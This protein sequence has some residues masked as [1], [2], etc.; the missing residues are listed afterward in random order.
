MPTAI[1]EILRTGRDSN[2]SYWV[3]ARYSDDWSKAWFNNTIFDMTRNLVELEPT[4]LIFSPENW[5]PLGAVEDTSGNVYRSDYKNHQLLHKLSCE[6]A[7]KPIECPGG[8]GWQTGQFNKPAGVSIDCRGSLLVADSGNHRVQIIKPESQTVIA[9]LG[10][11]SDLGGYL[12]GI[13]NGAMTEPVHAICDPRNYRIYVADRAGG[14]IHVFNDLYEY[15]YSFVPDTLPA[16]GEVPEKPVPLALAIA[17]DGSLL[18]LDANYSRIMRMSIKGK[19][20]SDLGFTTGDANPFIGGRNLQP[21]YVVKGEFVVGP[22][23][24]GVYNQTWH[25]INL[26]SSIPENT[27]V[28]VKSF[29]SNDDSIVDIDTIPWAP[30]EPVPI[31]HKTVTGCKKRPERLVLSDKQN[32][33]RYRHGDYRR[34]RPVISS[35]E[36]GDGP[37]S[38]D[39]VSIS[40]E[41]ARI[42]RVGDTVVFD[43]GASS[44]QLEIA[45]ISETDFRA[46]ANGVAKIYSQDTELWLVEQNGK[47][48]PG[49][50][51]HFYTLV[52]GELVDLSTAVMN[53]RLT[54]VVV[55]HSVA[56]IARIGDRLELRYAGDT[57]SLEIESVN[58]KQITNVVMSAAVGG[59][60][61]HS[62]LSLETSP[63]RLVCD[64]IY[65]FDYQ[66]ARHLK[67]TVDDEH[68]AEVSLV[69]PDV[70]TIWLEPGSTVEFGKWNY[71]TTMLP[72]ATDRGR[73]LWVRV[74]LNGALRRSGD[75]TAIATPVIY[76]VGALTPRPSYL[77]MLP[78]VYSR[79]E[80]DRDPV[81]SLFLER[82]LALFENRFTSMETTYEQLS[83]LLNIESTNEEWLT[84]LST[85]MGL[86]LDPSW[87]VMRRRRLLLEAMELF[88]KRGT[89]EGISRYLEIYT[90]KKPVILEGFRWRPASSMVIGRI[91][92]LGCSS[93]KADSCDYEPYAHRF[94]IHVFVEKTS[95]QDVIEIAVRNIIN[96]VKPAHTDYELI[97]N[98]PETRVGYQ[99]RVGIDMVLT[100]RPKNPFFIT[101]KKP[102]DKP[103][104]II[105]YNRL[106][107]NPVSSTQTGS[108]VL[109]IGG[110][111]TRGLTLN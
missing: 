107:S 47:T 94:G 41:Q 27:S 108:T 34:S 31:K 99:S 3:T 8:K 15:A 44:E 85:W 24:S 7:F 66:P 69:E 58:L 111:E 102:G 93:L 91:G 87:D 98:L 53:D 84:F 35:F 13:T 19:P 55:P 95:E 83:S 71:F 96:S 92:R 4:S 10:K 32:W 77:D 36:D 54:D 90:G 110:I 101:A 75:E 100:E 109:D 106:I 50:A 63:G 40:H 60:Y 51:R 18:V 74:Q 42:L 2:D 68:I 56:A 86:I 89:R 82:Y 28:S 79:A 39:L 22:F 81:G 49:G 14:M 72:V 78:A 1:Q 5:L 46:Y 37:S 43:T 76:S 6:K 104:S 25:K 48:V 16:F 59:D 30:I 88:Q 103:S 67:I 17:D 11:P 73:Y 29:A 61:S 70:A 26:E 33:E 23:D 57:A 12:A 105:G 64:D 52:A 45:S 62:T 38:S 20:L 80:A 97:L 65:G 9:V 21:R